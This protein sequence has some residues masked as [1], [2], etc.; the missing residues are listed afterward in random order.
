LHLITETYGK[1]EQQLDYLKDPQLGPESSVSKG[2][3]EIWRMK[4]RMMQ[5]AEQ[6]NEIFTITSNLLERARTKDASGVLPEAQL[7]DWVVWQAFIRSAVEADDPLSVV[8][9]LLV[10]F[11]NAQ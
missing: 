5:D 1:P 6:W 8:S 3:W 9:K 7:N 10:I 11:T 2:E 4:L